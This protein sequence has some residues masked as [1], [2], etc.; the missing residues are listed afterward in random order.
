MLGISEAAGR[1]GGQAH[2]LIANSGARSGSSYV[3]D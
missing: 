2:E 3:L 1:L